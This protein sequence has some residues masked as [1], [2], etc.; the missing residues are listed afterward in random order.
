MSYLSKRILTSIILLLV[1]FLSLQK[2]EILFIVIFMINYVVLTEFNQI[3]KKIFYKDTFNIFISILFSVIYLTIFTI[4]VW[5]HLN[6]LTFLNI[7]S[8]IFLLFICISTDIGGFVFGKLIGGKKL[9][10]ISPNKTFSGMIG[11]FLLAFVF[12]YLYFQLQ[13]NNLILANNVFLII[14]II[15]LISQI[16]DLSISYLKRKAK[17]K[18]TGSILPGHGGL[19]DRIDGILIAIPVGILLL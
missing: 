11:S 19:L 5:V 3:F 6:S 2:K 16:G 1:I 12:G 7:N 14:F 8:F 9:T 18:D 13:K 10:K 15:S 17:L 4:F